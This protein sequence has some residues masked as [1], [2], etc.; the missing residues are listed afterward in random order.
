MV[1][2][3]LI[4]NTSGG[5]APLVVTALSNQPGKNAEFTFGDGFSVRGESATHT[6]RDAG[7]YS[8]HCSTGEQQTTHEI[9][10]LEAVPTAF[11]PNG[12]GAND[13]YTIANPEIREIELRIY[14]RGGRLV[15]SGKAE[16]VNWNG[17]Y[18]DGNPAETGTYFYDIFVTSARGNTYKQKGTLTLFR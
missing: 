15:Y 4:V 10:V 8:I 17:L 18:P 5:F 3:R 16:S 13:V 7:V 12:D 1:P 6:Y 9:E 14:T 2:L 11:S